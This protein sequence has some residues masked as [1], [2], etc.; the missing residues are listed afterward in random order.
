[1]AKK[2]KRRAKEYQNRKAD[3]PT[4]TTS[5]ETRSEA[6]L[7]STNVYRVRENDMQR[8]SLAPVFVP[9]KFKSG[10]ETY[11][12]T[13]RNG[14]AALRP[15]KSKLNMIMAKEKLEV[16]RRL[17]TKGSN[18]EGFV[19]DPITCRPS[20]PSPQSGSVSCSLPSV[21]K[22]SSEEQLPSNNQLSFLPKIQNSSKNS[23]NRMTIKEKYMSAGAPT[24]SPSNFVQESCEIRI[25]PQTKMGTISLL[26]QR[27]QVKPSLVRKPSIGEVTSQNS[28][29][30]N[31]MKLPVPPSLPKQKDLL[32]VNTPNIRHRKI[33]IR[34]RRDSFNVKNK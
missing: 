33:K 21:E 1:M 30:T 8:K 14:P 22:L 34:Q 12:E 29:K 10:F 19:A 9:N 18:L 24:V 2:D 4:T 11:S 26:S 25:L 32:S 16:T 17:E 13:V 31:Q 28:E 6:K 27:Q 15:S 23:I 5:E 7:D 3:S 20:R